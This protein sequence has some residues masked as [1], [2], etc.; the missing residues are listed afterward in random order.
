VDLSPDLTALV[1]NLGPW[2]VALLAFLETSFLTGLLVP[3]GPAVIVA[4]T[5]AL[6]GVLRLEWVA[7][8]AVSGALL[9]D[10]VGF[11]VGRRGGGR[12]A[13]GT[14]HLGGMARRTE[15]RA[16]RLFRRHPVFAVSG[17]RLLSF[18]RTLMPPAA[19]M[20]QLSYRQF[21]L[22]DT[23]GVA[24]WATAYILAGVATGEGWNAVSE[25]LGTGGAILF[26]A[27]VLFLALGFRRQKRRGERTPLGKPPAAGPGVK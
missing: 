4:T 23:L 15:S 5:L 11:W 1:T 3:C 12:V 21:L 10:S 24:G 26:V 7:V 2:V 18:V 9:G 20:S 6:E 25:I 8:A 14:G 22:Y 19:G 17:A 13:E 16:R 27:L